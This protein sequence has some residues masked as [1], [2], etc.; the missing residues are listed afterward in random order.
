GGGKQVAFGQDAQRAVPRCYRCAKADKGVLYRTYKDC[1]L[2]GGR[3]GAHAF[4]CPTA[5]SDEDEIRALALCHVFQHAAG[6]GPEAFSQVY[7][8]HGAPEA[9]EQ[10][11]VLGELEGISERLTSLADAVG[12]SLTT[13]STAGGEAG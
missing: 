5:E 2:G 1:P 12:L 4:Y 7:D 9:K 10:D 6:D 13:A 3:P 8:V 11:E